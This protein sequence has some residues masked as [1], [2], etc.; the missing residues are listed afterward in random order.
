MIDFF[1]KSPIKSFDTVLDVLNYLEDNWVPDDIEYELFDSGLGGNVQQKASIRVPRVG[2]NTANSLFALTQVLRD[3]RFVRR[4]QKSEPSPF[5]ENES[6]LIAF[7]SLTN[8]GR[9]L[10]YLLK[11]I[12]AGKQFLSLHPDGKDDEGRRRRA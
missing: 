6:D 10:R 9:K 3:F 2:G 4:R 8:A 12:D 7:Y 5:F 1:S 11:Q